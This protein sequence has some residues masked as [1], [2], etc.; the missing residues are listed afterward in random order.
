MK[1]KFRSQPN[2]IDAPVENQRPTIP[3]VHADSRLFPGWGP[4]F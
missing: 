1:S 3:P 4:K 2:E